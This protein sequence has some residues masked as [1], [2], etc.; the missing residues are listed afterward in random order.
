MQGQIQR[1]W[2]RYSTENICVKPGKK[3]EGEEN[4]RQRKR[5]NGGAPDIADHTSEALAQQL[6]RGFLLLAE[7]QVG[8]HEGAAD[9]FF[10]ILIVIFTHH[11][12]LSCCCRYFIVI[13]NCHIYSSY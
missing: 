7:G 2:Y 10:V 8:R 1:T 9:I 13:F 6:L 11:I 5:R 3:T 12:E 4:K